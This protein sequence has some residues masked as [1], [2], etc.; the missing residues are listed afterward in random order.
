MNRVVRF[1]PLRPISITLGGRVT[2]DL[3]V[4][5]WSSLDAVRHFARCCAAQTIKSEVTAMF[6]SYSRVIRDKAS[7]SFLRN[8]FFSHTSFM[9]GHLPSGIR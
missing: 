4:L 1:C 9:P 3:R 6:R 8:F 7:Q 5:K 2:S